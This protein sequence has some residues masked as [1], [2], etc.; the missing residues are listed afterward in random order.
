M[1]SFQNVSFL[2]SIIV[3]AG[4]VALWGVLCLI[5]CR[6]FAINKR[7]DDDWFEDDAEK[8]WWKYDA[9]KTETK[10]NE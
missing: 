6:F 8:G 1:I 9:T 2:G 7:D 3:W 5:I 10:E 4:V